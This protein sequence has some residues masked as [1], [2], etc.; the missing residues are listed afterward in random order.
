[1]LEDFRGF[2]IT[3]QGSPCVVGLELRAGG[4]N[5]SGW[6][7]TPDRVYTAVTK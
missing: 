3:S 7:T 1:M 2:S 6:S 4:A 5:L